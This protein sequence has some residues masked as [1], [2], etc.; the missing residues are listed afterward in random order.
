MRIGL[1]YEVGACHWGPRL[2]SVTPARM[3][4]PPLAWDTPTGSPKRSAPAAAPTS[5][6]R[7]MKALAT[8]ADTRACPYAKSVNGRSVPPSASPTTASR[9]PGLEGAAGIPAIV[10][11]TG[12]G[13]AGGAGD[14][15]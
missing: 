2:L 11:A 3:A 9:V 7:L 13:G 8:S 14:W 12:G 4:A 1:V 15:I 10:T 5:G 6:S